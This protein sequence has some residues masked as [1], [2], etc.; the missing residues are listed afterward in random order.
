MA[1]TESTYLLCFYFRTKTFFNKVTV[2]TLPS[3]YRISILYHILYLF[4]LFDEMK[5][6]YISINWTLIKIY[7]WIT[8]VFVPFLGPEI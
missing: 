1:T 3:Y 2:I 4:F 5:N 8:Y 7:K 6:Y